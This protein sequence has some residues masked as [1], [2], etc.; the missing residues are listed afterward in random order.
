MKHALGKTPKKQISQ[1]A[2]PLF[3]DTHSRTVGESLRILKPVKAGLV[4]ATKQR[5]TNLKGFPPR[6]H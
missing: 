3:S 6:F 1:N 4:I 2:L 5:E